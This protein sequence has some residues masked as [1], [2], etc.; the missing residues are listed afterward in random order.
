MCR[1]LSFNLLPNTG[2]Q[3]EWHTKPLTMGVGPLINRDQCKV[4]YYLSL[5]RLWI[6]HWLS[7]VKFTFLSCELGHIM[8]TW[9][10]LEAK[11]FWAEQLVQGH[12]LIYGLML[13][14]HVN[15]WCEVFLWPEEHTDSEKYWCQ[16]F[17][18][19]LMGF[20]HEKLTWPWS[21]H[22]WHFFPKCNRNIACC[23]LKW[24]VRQK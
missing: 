8:M 20:F 18:P 13:G 7:L 12:M 11:W 17:Y 23:T 10:D 16:F 15:L 21:R 4:L 6:D 1:L 5:W 2:S 9:Y 22:E 3:P 14:N 19:C 24:P